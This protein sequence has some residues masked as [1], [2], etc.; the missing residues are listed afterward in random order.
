M[1]TREDRQ[2]GTLRH[3]SSWLG[4]ESPKTAVQKLEAA[5]SA[6]KSEKKEG[7]GSR[8]EGMCEDNEDED[9]VLEVSFKCNSSSGSRWHDVEDQWKRKWHKEMV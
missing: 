4:S 6:G 1:K 2:S 5:A 8:D 9:R 3:Q 7:T